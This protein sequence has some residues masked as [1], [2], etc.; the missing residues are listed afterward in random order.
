MGTPTGPR[1]RL[2]TFGH[3]L[4]EIH[5][6]LREELAQLRA[7]VDAY[8]DGR[9]A[10][11]RELKAHCLSFCTALTRHH[12]GEDAGAFPLLGDLHPEL[13][14]VIAKLE[15]DH[16]LVSS[17]V[18][19]LEQLLDGITDTPDPA[20]AKRVRGELDGLSAILESHFTFEERRITAALDALPT[21]AGT[22][23]T[24]F[25]LTVGEA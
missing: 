24:L 16:Q 5:Q 6:W 1:A 3:E 23:E 20:E 21:E 2:T 9:A 25:G 7:D 18:R 13:R 22:T 15:E 4:T 19:G 14:P 11:P 10:R 12:T 17:I 8:L